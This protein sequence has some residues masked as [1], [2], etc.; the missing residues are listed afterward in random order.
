MWKLDHEKD[1][2]QAY[3]ALSEPPDITTF[4][5]EGLREG[6][7]MSAAYHLIAASPD[8]IPACS[9]C[10]KGAMESAHFTKKWPGDHHQEFVI[11]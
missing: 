6:G 7:H 11:K 8:D 4:S 10:S 2:F 5:T 3:K 1:A 9:C